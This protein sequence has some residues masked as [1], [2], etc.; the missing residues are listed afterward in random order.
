MKLLAVS[1]TYHDNNLTYFDGEKIYYHKLE[2]TK[3]VKRYI[4][5]SPW[6]WIRDAEELWNFKIEDIDEVAIDCDLNRLVGKLGHVEFVFEDSPYLYYKIPDDKNPFLIYGVKNIWH[7]NHHYSHA[8]STWM[9]E[10]ENNE[11]ETRIVI[12][13]VGDEKTVTVF[14]NHE[15]IKTIPMVNGSIGLKMNWIGDFLGIQSKNVNDQAGKAMGFQSYGQVNDLFLKTISQFD[16]EHINEI[17]DFEL[18][19]KHIGDPLIARH[20]AIHWAKTVHKR[21]EEVIVDFFNNYVSKNDIVSYSGGVAQNVVWNTELLK[22]FNN[23]I[24]PPHSSDEGTSLGLIEFLRKKNNLKKFTMKNF[25]YCQNDNAPNSEPT[26]KTIKYAAKLL[27][28]GYIIGWYQGNSEIGPRALGNRS[29]LMDPRIKDGKRIINQ[30]KK[31]ENYRPFGASI[32]S[33]HV[34]DYFEFDIKDPYMLFTNNFIVNDFPAITHVDN[35][36]RVQT[37][38]KKSGYFRQLIE[39]FYNI[40]GC[41]IILNTSLNINGK[42]IAGYE[43]NAIDLFQSSD[44][45]YMFIGNKILEKNKN[46]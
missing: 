16:I 33:E 44:I 8:L 28:E 4:W 43:E 35:T 34:K 21:V 19:E 32:L 20:T 39:E 6:Q 17:F 25:P 30:V 7:V 45:D 23:I 42:P 12:D 29:I 26:E 38:E 14:K 31:R 24:I 13:G 10:D 36:C 41:A 5:D 46:G 1:M 40:T 3:Q 18:W 15:K 22:N 11:P 9:L 2:R 37:V 27:S